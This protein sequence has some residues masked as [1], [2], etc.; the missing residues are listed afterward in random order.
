MTS[1]QWFEDTAIRTITVDGRRVSSVA[2]SA[3]WRVVIDEEPLDSC[4]SHTIPRYCG[5]VK[6]DP[7]P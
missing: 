2:G 6:F 3:G 1:S 5:E 7:S 4:A